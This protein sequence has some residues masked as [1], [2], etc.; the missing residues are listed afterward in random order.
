MTLTFT[1]D[2]KQLLKC[3]I[4]DQNI[5]RE[6]FND[7]GLPTDIHLVEYTVD[8]VLYV[9]VVRAYKVVDIFDPYYDK[10]KTLGGELISITNG[11]GNLRP[12]MYQGDTP[13][14]G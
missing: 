2:E 8:D 14:N 13:A 10:L 6:N 4:F 1:T 3:N 11:Y 7:K 5:D 9:D 12:N